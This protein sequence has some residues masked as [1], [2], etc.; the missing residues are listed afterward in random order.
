MT[1][2]VIAVRREVERQWS[3]FAWRTSLLGL[4]GSLAAALLVA[5]GGGGGG[6]E[7][8]APSW[9]AG[10]ANGTTGLV[11]AAPAPG[12]LL[13]PD[14]AVY[15]PLRA[16]S[17]WQYRQAI[18]TRQPAPT[19]EVAM[20]AG[21]A[22]RFVE[23]RT[24]TGTATGSDQTIEFWRAANGDTLASLSLPLGVGR[25]ITL[26]GPDL[27]RELRAGQLI[28]AFDTRRADIGVD[29]DG[30]G[31][32]DGAD[33]A[34]WRVV[35]GFENLDLPASSRPVRAL[36]VNDH[37]VVRTLSSRG[38]VI[39]SSTVYASTW[40]REGSGVVRTVLWSDATATAATSDEL[41]VGYDGVDRGFGATAL[42]RAAGSGGQAVPL[43]S[44]YLALADDGQ[45]L[46]RA[47]ARGE[48]LGESSARRPGEPNWHRQ[49]LPTAS[50]IRMAA[51]FH[52]GDSRPSQF[53][54]DALDAEGLL[55][56]GP[57]A[58]HTFAPVLQLS[59]SPFS[60]V[61]VG[62]HPA[63]D[64]IWLA[65]RD[66]A[67]VPLPGGGFTSEP[68]LVLLRYTADGV[69]LGSMTLP[70]AQD[71]ST[72]RP[73]VLALAD[74]A[75]V[76]ISESSGVGTGVH[77][78]VEMDNGGRVLIDRRYA[79]VTPSDTIGDRVVGQVRVVGAQR[80]LVWA[81]PLPSGVGSIRPHAMRLAPDGTPL[82]VADTAAGA[83]G[84]A[85]PWPDGL[86]L[87]AWPVNALQEAG[88]RWTFPVSSALPGGTSQIGIAVFDASGG[89]PRAQPVVRWTP[90]PSNQGNRPWVTLP[91][92]TLFDS[93]Y[94][95]RFDGNFSTVLWHE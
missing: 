32:P 95:V 93:G 57:R 33:L 26:S 40:Y 74:R 62:S 67:T 11:P 35:V 69:L 12:A 59:D 86:S 30:D 24:D 16:G 75:F 34:Y 55:L 8:A 72:R 94:G 13:V 43:G 70:S 2:R 23:S 29:L 63:S 37:F 91:D 31:R 51:V 71:R 87:S 47:N 50:G 6:G 42:A 56:P 90:L 9:P 19:V 44:G 84:S 49:L 66:S 88:Q 36:R 4:V 38:G 78:L 15:R 85:L 58:V 3:R 68:R 61:G 54:L 83:L 77:R 10:G 21:S 48:R 25:S 14:S 52:R 39:A 45:T 27:T 60:A 20:R 89:D 22:D 1:R 17:R 65:Y 76:L 53:E 41:L 79:L 5:C 73:Q 7:P 92:R 82:D 46:V 80:W 64:V 81:D 28:T 18:N